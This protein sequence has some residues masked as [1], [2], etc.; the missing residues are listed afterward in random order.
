MH[1]A[2]RRIGVPLPDLHAHVLDANLEP[3]PPGFEGELYVAGPGL[4]RGYLG[5][6]GLSA[7]R[8][9]PDPQ[10]AQG[11]RLYRTGDL[12]RQV[13]GGGLEYLGRIDTQVKLRGFR[14]EIGEVEAALKQL[15]GVADAVAVVQGEDEAQRLVAY[16]VAVR[17]GAALQ[18]GLF[19]ATAL[20]HL[21]QALR[22]VVPGYMVPAQ[23]V[24]LARLPL[25]ENGKLDRRALPAVDLVSLD[26]TD[27]VGPADE[28]ERKLAAIWCSVLEVER[29]GVTRNFLDAGGHSLSAVKVAAQI[30]QK[31]DVEV[32]LTIVFD[33]PTIRLLADWI[34]QAR[35]ADPVDARMDDMLALLEEVKPLG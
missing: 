23:L 14:I 26:D 9:V 35:A 8:F 28:I 16:V 2:S 25:T 19:D 10:G 24:P 21:R 17:Q 18:A 13:S 7:E 5:R 6:P 32:P 12:V 27:E 34:R 15:D 22:Q 3:V 1:A 20:D 11:A 29:V 4:A 30:R 31:L 33:Q